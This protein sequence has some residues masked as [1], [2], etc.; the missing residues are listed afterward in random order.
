MTSSIDA[1]CDWLESISLARGQMPT[2]F[3]YAEALGREHFELQ[4]N[5]VNNAFLRA[6]LRSQELGSSYPF[7]VGSNFIVS[8]PSAME[9]VYAQSLLVSDGTPFRT[10]N[11]WD[12]NKASKAF[13]F[14]VESAMQNFFGDHTRSVNFGFPSAVG[15]P[16]DFSAAIEWL[17][18]L[19]SAKL[20]TAYRSPRKKDGGVDVVVWKDF[21]DG[22]GGLPILL[23]QA[24]IMHDFINK[25]GDV[26]LRLW[27]GWL[28]TDAEP[29]VALAVPVVVSDKNVWSEIS[30]R[31]LLMDRMR[32]A[33]LAGSTKPP[34]HPILVSLRDALAEVIS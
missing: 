18:K 28:S 6:S 17:A 4:D 3:Q 11:V 10:Q 27:S 9:S 34:T 21:Q 5:D 25:I 7:T 30:A 2:G 15:R 33:K 29:L 13:E 26:D 14:T 24:T 19:A 8:K 20:G 22:H 12:S 23:L 16:K 32:L 31:G 1:L